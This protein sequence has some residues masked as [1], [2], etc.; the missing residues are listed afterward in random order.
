VICQGQLSKSLDRKNT[1]VEEV[2]L[3]MTGLNNNSNSDNSK[4]F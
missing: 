3:L 1:N 2:G 4:A